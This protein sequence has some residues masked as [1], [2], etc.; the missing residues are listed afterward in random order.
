MRDGCCFGDCV[1]GDFRVGLAVGL[2]GG[3][4]GIIGQQDQ[5]SV[6]ADNRPVTAFA[7]RRFVDPR[8]LTR[9]GIQAE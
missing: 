7:A 8:C 5:T 3:Q 6:S 4:F 1:A 9:P 2:E